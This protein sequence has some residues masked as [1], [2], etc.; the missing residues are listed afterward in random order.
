MALLYPTYFLLCQYSCKLI[1]A[2]QAMRLFGEFEYAA[3]SWSQAH[4]VVLKAEVLAGSNG[5]PNKDNE[6]F[7]VTTLRSPTPSTLY[8]QEY[9]GQIGRA[10][11]R[12]RV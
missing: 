1:P 12:E 11:C 4:R 2:I 7:V 3:K 10:S 6:R 5:A 8:Q 9:C